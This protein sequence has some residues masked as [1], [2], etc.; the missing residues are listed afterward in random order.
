MNCY[1]VQSHG[2]VWPLPAFIA[3]R[4]AALLLPHCH[5]RATAELVA[6]GVALALWWRAQAAEGAA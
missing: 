2:A 1:V 3:S 5:A 6:V 4:E